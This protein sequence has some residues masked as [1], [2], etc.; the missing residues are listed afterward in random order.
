MPTTAFPHDIERDIIERELDVDGRTVQ[1]SM[2]VAWCGAIG[3]VL[4]PVVTLPTGPASDGLPV[5]VQVVGPY[6]SDL[7]LLEIARQLDEVA[8]SG[9]IPPP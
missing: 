9:F 5:G 4:L 6:L 8:G 2:A 7:R 3:A 1:H